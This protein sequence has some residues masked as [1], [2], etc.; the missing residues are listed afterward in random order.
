MG[1]VDGLSNE[2]SKK[3]DQLDK[4]SQDLLQMVRPDSRRSTSAMVLKDEQEFNRV[5]I[6]EAQR[7]VSMSASMKRLSWITVSCCS[8]RVLRE[9]HANA[10]NSSYSFL[11]HS[12]RY[13]P[14]MQR[15]LERF[16]WT[17]R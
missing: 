1:T 6:R 11:S 8:R 7:S 13:V 10:G 15:T 3:L 5:S 12:W 2:I 17:L 14:T 4:T 16:L 9:P